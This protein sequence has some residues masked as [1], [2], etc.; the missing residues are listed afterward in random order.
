ME[1]SGSHSRA[2]Q[3]ATPAQKVQDLQTRTEV[4]V[5]LDLESEPESSQMEL[6]ENRHLLKADLFPVQLV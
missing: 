3:L 5:L 1:P 2:P 4:L 6:P